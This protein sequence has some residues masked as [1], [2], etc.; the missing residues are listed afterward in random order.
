MNL[1]VKILLFVSNILPNFIN[2]NPCIYEFLH[3]F[4]C[5]L[6]FFMFTTKSFFQLFDKIC[7]R[8]DFIFQLIHFSHI[9]TFLYAL[10]LKISD[11]HFF[12][13][14]CRSPYD[15]Y[16]LI[17]IERILSSGDLLY[18]SKRSSIWCA[19]MSQYFSK[20]FL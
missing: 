2:P 15:L 14:P 16:C 5:F 20:E 19:F 7:Q 18:L 11:S 17:S 8:N 1:L 12:G 4:L 3:D 6:N 13:N 10:E 9:F